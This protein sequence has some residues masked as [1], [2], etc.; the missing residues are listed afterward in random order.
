[1]LASLCALYYQIT[2]YF[3]NWKIG[4]FILFP[5]ILFG[6]FQELQNSFPFA[7]FT[8]ELF[9]F[10]FLIMYYLNQSTLV[11]KKILKLSLVTGSI[12]NFLFWFNFHLILTLVPIL[13]YLSLFRIEKTSIIYKKIFVYIVGFSSGFIFTTII[14]WVISGAL[15]GSEIWDS[16]KLAL[17]TRLGTTGLNGPLSEYSSNFSGL[18]VSLR[19]IVINLM[20]AASKIVDPRNASFAG[21]LIISIIIMILITW[22][23][24]KTKFGKALNMK[25]FFAAMP[26]FMI[27]YFYYVLTPNHSFNH[28]VLSYRAVPLS[29]GFIIG[30][31]YLSGSRMEMN[32]VTN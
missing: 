23:L 18:P 13:I 26:V 10:G 25:E 30:L 12:Y 24:Y 1:M 5:F 17:D 31:F 19:A 11:S 3:R 29:I 27:P 9:I 21:V 20:V 16:I 22:F 4:L 8:I 32:K 2:K 28:A 14:K 15:F 6:D 7:L